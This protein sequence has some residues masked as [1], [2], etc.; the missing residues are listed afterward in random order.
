MGLWVYDVKEKRGSK[1]LNGAFER[2]SWSS[3]MKQI[4]IGRTY[5]GRHHGIWVADTASLGPG[6][7][8]E[9]HCHEMVD[10][11]TRRINF[12][13]EN[14][15]NYL[16][17]A[18]YHI[19]LQNRERAS[20]DIE[21]CARLLGGRG[22]PAASVVTRLQENWDDV[23]AVFLEV[24]AFS[25]GILGPEKP[26]MLN[27]I[28]W[29]QATCPGAD[30]RD[31]AKAVENATK[32]CELTN[33]KNDMYLDTLAAAYAEAGDFDEAIKWQKKAIELMAKDDSI[34]P[35]K[36]YEERLKLYQSGQP[37]RVTP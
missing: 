2:C 25:R 6:R 37:Y 5:A 24:L 27:A 17:R 9:K 29:L 26:L 36:E 22:H 20:A 11:Y 21:T 12:E 3:D 7:T 15:G 23:D 10:F 16:W 32:A 35:Y 30:F 34:P 14:A 1:L 18:R 31:G 13:P 8:V 4:A 28:A 33:W 19:H